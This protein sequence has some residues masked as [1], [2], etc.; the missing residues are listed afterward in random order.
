MSLVLGGW[1]WQ[2]WGQA[3]HPQAAAGTWGCL[4]RE[5]GVQFISTDVNSGPHS[6]SVNVRSRDMGSSGALCRDQVGQV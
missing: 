4:V 2:I 5:G 6:G 3:D 1:G